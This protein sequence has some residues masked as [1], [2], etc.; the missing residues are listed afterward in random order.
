VIDL[1]LKSFFDRVNYDKPMGL[2]RRKINDKM[3]LRLIRCYLSSGIL[4]GGV[5]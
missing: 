5:G 1:D 2:L 3:L 4:L